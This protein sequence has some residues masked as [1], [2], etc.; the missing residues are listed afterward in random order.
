M[1]EEDKDLTDLKGV[2]GKT[3]E[4]LQEAGLDDLMSIATLSSGELAEKAD[5]GESSAQKII[6]SARRQADIGGFQTGKEKYDQRKEMKR[7]LTN[8]DDLDEI[9]GGGVETQAITEFYGE[10]GSAK[11]QLSHQLATNVQL[12]EGEGGLGKGAIYIDTEDTFIPDRIEQ[13]AEAN[14]QD[15]EEVLN[16]I[17]VARAFNSDHQVLLADEAQDIAQKEDIGLIIVDSLTAQFRSDYV[18]RGELA[19]RQQKLN[20]HMNTLL[21]IANS[22]NIAVVVTNQVMSNPDQMFGDPTKAIG[23]HIV[24]HNSAVRIYLRKGKKDKRVARLVDSPYMPEAEAVF[25]IEDSG[26]VND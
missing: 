25:R 26:I 23:G 11:T 19:P 9:L 12:P 7:I 15:P 20:K 21:R 17:H 4:K 16:N 22:H 18:G 1:A 13:M 8:C 10:Y 5:V 24:A 6:S 14:G 2:G 3:A